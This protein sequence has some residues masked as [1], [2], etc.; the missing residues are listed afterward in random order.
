MSD[1]VRGPH[2]PP[3]PERAVDLADFARLLRELVVLHG[4]PPLRE[5]AK[6]MGPLLRPPRAPAKS[7]ISDMFA[8]G[9]RRISLDLVIALVR[10][11]G[12]DERGI[13]SWRQA[14]VRVHAE[15][16]QGGQV[17]VHRQLPADLATFTGRERELKALLDAAT[18]SP[19]GAPATMVIAAV[20]GMGGIGKTQLAIRA[21]HQLVADGRYGD[22]QLYVNLRGFDAELPPADPSEVLA[23]L[24]R[25][26]GV[27]SE[28]VP[29]GR[30]ER[31]AMFRDRIHGKDAIVVLDNAADAAQV[32]HLIPGSPEVLVLI[33]SRR[34][35]ASLESA[36]LHQLTLFSDAESMTLLERVVGADR[37][38]AEPAAARELVSRCGGLPLALSL[39]AARLR[40]RPTW[41]LAHML[42]RLD[43]TTVDELNVA[44]RSLGAVLELSYRGL[45][46]RLRNAYPLLALHP[47]HDFTPPAI[48]ALLDRPVD[49]AEQLLEDLLDA[50]LL[51]QREAGRYELHDL[52]RV[53]ASRWAAASLPRAEQDAAIIRVL[54]WYTNAMDAAS[55]V[56]RAA[57]VLPELPTE[58]A[59][60][61]TPRFDTT[62]DAMSWC[63]R[64]RAN[65]VAAVEHAVAHDLP[66]LSW[67]LPLA[68]A[69]YAGLLADWPDMHRLNLLAL[70]S[71][72]QRT[73]PAARAWILRNL[74]M[75][76]TCIGQAEQGMAWAEEALTIW[77][78]LG[79]RGGEMR[80]LGTIADLRGAL[81]QPAAAVLISDQVIDLA[82]QL[83][84][85]HFERVRLM[86]SGVDLA[87]LRRFDEARER[88]N[89][90]L[91]MLANDDH[92]ERAQ[93]LSNIGCLEIECERF[94]A[95][96]R[97]F[98]QAL[99]HADAASDR[100]NQAEA[101]SGIGRS[102]ASRDLLE[103]ARPCYEQ[104]LA[105]LSAMGNPEAEVIK[106]RLRHPR[107]AHPS[108]ATVVVS[109]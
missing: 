107:L 77:R 81:G 36:T 47:G 7:T 84:D 15:A 67:R 54:S 87:I 106:E 73:D 104:A 61:D 34:S 9:R 105:L 14:C 80:T 55:V 101:L 23:G 53:C 29:E 102:L 90:A 2:D 70:R 65:L 32:R 52:L 30:D 48:A 19:D 20:E 35:L 89:A 72:D 42:E 44:D 4:N 71:P 51:E 93:A 13:D 21:A 49:E 28:H 1:V 24:L 94:E 95:A 43:A 108:D 92:V 99:E 27:S 31:A 60:A 18:R 78:T 57:R 45:D 66:V 64:E 40:S 38:D 83:G 100:R 86:N 58:L 59:R 11:L 79:D 10:A 62:A 50:H 12:V 33:T 8:P 46:G 6:R 37:V 76:A 75:S 26:L 39:V 25:A 96:E 5:L 74:A 91:K 69:T 56:L 63:E 3:D 97:A 103:E 68:V 22:L 88:M 16:K 41:T 85:R 109:Y 82:R 17:G 98:R